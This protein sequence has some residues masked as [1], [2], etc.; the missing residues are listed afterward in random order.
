[1]EIIENLRNFLKSCIK[2][3]NFFAFLRV[4]CRTNLERTDTLK[5]NKRSLTEKEE[6][7]C[8]NYVESQEVEQSAKKAGF[9]KNSL[10]KGYR[11]LKKQ[12]ILDE[13]QSI[14]KAKQTVF[15]KMSALG[16]GRLAF[17]SISDAVT[18][19]Y[20]ENPDTLQL[21]NMDLF[22]IS[23]IKKLKDGAMEIKFFDRLKALDNL[24]LKD[25]DISSAQ[26]GLIQALYQGAQ[27]IS[28]CKDGIGEL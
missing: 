16:L 13:I 28:D 25:T 22:C 19:L 24:K 20:M 8:I 18:L 12:E 14:I 9:A 23:E 3:C 11:L 5:N 2:V 4:K 17:G 10:Q 7:F 27:S 15:T 26:N 21:K 6:L 1:M